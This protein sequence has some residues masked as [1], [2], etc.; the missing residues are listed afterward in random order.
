MNAMNLEIDDTLYIDGTNYVVVRNVMAGWSE[1]VSEY[2][3]TKQGITESYELTC[4][5]GS[6]RF[7]LIMRGG[8]QEFLK[9]WRWNPAEE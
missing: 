7:N 4:V 5:D 3:R 1:K 9:V 2:M 8:Q 6:A